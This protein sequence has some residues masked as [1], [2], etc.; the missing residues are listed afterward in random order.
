[1]RIIENYLLENTG[2]YYSPTN[3]KLIKEFNYYLVTNDIKNGEYMIV[4]PINYLYPKKQCYVTD[5]MITLTPSYVFNE[6]IDVI[7]FSAKFNYYV[8]N[9]F[10]FST[11]VYGL[12]EQNPETDILT[13]KTENSSGLIIKTVDIG[14]PIKPISPY[15]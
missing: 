12:F 5:L 1:M 4:K 10:S 6:S 3:T 9:S 7:K 2:A 14:K 8:E 11:T 13:D 15:F